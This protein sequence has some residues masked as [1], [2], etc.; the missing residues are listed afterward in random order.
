MFFFT[1]FFF[2]TYLFF[3]FKFGFCRKCGLVKILDP[4][5]LRNYIFASITAINILEFTIN[6]IFRIPD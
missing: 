5:L 3:L 4:V 6:V 1:S 2:F